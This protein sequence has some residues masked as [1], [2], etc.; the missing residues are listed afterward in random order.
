MMSQKFISTVKNWDIYKLLIL[1]QGGINHSSLNK[2]Q[3]ING[4]ESSINKMF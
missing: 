3:R 4:V 2:K 1:I